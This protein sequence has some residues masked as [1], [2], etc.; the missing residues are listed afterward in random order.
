MLFI[1]FAG[2]RR[3]LFFQRIL[4][5]RCVEFGVLSVTVNVKFGEYA[6]I[7]V[8]MTSADSEN[9]ASS[10]LQSNNDDPF[11]TMINKTG[12]MDFHYKVQVEICTR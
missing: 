3:F 4:I 8:I 7:T 6:I 9:N 1:V 11:E 2:T 12:C 5:W 10:E